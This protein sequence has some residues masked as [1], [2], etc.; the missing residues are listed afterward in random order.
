MRHAVFEGYGIDRNKQSGSA[1]FPP[2]TN[3]QCLQ[4]H[5]QTWSAPFVRTFLQRPCRI[6]YRQCESCPC[7]WEPASQPGRRGTWKTE[8]L[9][10]AATS[11][12]A[13]KTSRWTSVSAWGR[14][15]S[16]PCVFQRIWKTCCLCKT[17][18]SPNG[19]SN[20]WGNIWISSL[21]K[22]VLAF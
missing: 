8:T 21:S 15:R 18:R 6:F 2:E 10:A 4:G 9:G 5:N 3:S 11:P 19:N 1:L 12:G 16:R 7:L 22:I 17:G 20:C 14:S 13:G